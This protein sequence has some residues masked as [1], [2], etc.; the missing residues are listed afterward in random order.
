[1]KKKKARMDLHVDTSEESAKAWAD[2]Q[3]EFKANRLGSEQREREAGSRRRLR[4]YYGQINLIRCRECSAEF[5]RFSGDHEKCR[6][7]H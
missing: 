2:R 1:V 4:K 3:A 6:D 7:C 5:E